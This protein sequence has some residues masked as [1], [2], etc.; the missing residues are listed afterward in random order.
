MDIELPSEKVERIKHKFLSQNEQTMLND[1]WALDI[2]TL[3]NDGILTTGIEQ[4]AL[5]HLTLLW[6]CKEAIFKWWGKGN[7]DFSDMMQLSGNFPEDAGALFGRFKKD[8]VNSSFLIQYKIFP[9]LILTWIA[10]F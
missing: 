5:E 7:V 8:E 4:I 9:S 1:E 10:Y 2:L 6:S 3:Q